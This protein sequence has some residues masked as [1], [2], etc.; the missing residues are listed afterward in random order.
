ME[1]CIYREM[2]LGDN[3]SFHI[4]EVTLRL[5]VK[6]TLELA[7]YLLPSRHSF[8]I[9]LQLPFTQECYLFLSLKYF[10]SC[11]ML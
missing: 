8:E 4:N 5:S 6:T 2:F 1:K 11:W 9:Y 10:V 7:L 3:T